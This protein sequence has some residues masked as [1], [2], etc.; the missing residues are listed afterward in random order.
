MRHVLTPATATLPSGF[1]RTFTAAC[2]G[3]RNEV[4]LVGTSSGEVVVVALDSQTYRG[5]VPVSSNGV[6]T[7]VRAP[8]LG[9]IM[10][11]GDGTVKIFKGSDVSWQCIG[12]AKLKCVS[13]ACARCV[14]VV[15][16]SVILSCCLCFCVCS[17]LR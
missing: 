8:A 2:C 7:M 13:L 4:L 11:S 5:T 1:E 17:P 9:V 3:P 15:C 10:G 6:L 14:G 16:H 12:E